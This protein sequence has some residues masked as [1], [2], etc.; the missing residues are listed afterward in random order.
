MLPEAD[1]WL[2]GM[3]YQAA[4]KTLTAVE[5]AHAPDLPRLVADLREM[6]EAQKTVLK[7]YAEGKRDLLQKALAEAQNL[8]EMLDKIEPSADCASFLQAAEVREEDVEVK[9]GDAE[10]AAASG[11]ANTVLLPLM[12][13]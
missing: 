13:P 10:T 3:R 9:E 2:A 7:S 5:A 8:C 12:F 11:G 6:D 4:C 1:P